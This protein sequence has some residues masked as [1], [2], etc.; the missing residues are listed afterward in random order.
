MV[1]FPE[2]SG[3]G[4]KAVQDAI[5]GTSPTFGSNRWNAA[6]VAG[7]SRTGIIEEVALLTPLHPV[8]PGRVRR[9]ESVVRPA[10]AASHRS[11]PHWIHP[12]VTD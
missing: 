12:E 8:P 4:R 5:D 7:R 6:V 3:D 10:L 9:P 11:P 1:W 2:C